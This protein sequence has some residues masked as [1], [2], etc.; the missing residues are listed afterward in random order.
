MP[1]DQLPSDPFARAVHQPDRAIDLARAALLIAR[2]QYPDLDID[3]YVDKLDRM[4]EA[5]RLNIAAESNHNENAEILNR[6]LFD[7]LGFAG[8]RQDYY[9]PHNS[10]LNYVLEH[11]TGIPITLSVVYIEVGRRLHLPIQGVGLPGHFIVRY[12]GATPA[13]IDPF[14][15]GERLTEVDC[16]QRLHAIFGAPV[17]FRAEWLEPVGKRQILTRMLH[18]LKGIYVRRED[19]GRAIPIVEKI[20]TLNPDAYTELRDLGSL[21]GMAGNYGDALIYLQQYLAHRPDAP[22]VDSVQ[23]QMR[24]LTTRMA[25]WN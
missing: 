1:H 8:N 11:R 4:A 13:F 7:E 17:A 25:R 12:D 19:F 5:V 6:Y 10:F 2:D 18:N 20:L 15:A 3:H 24:R 16:Q 21:H 23:S 22:D 9:N 14:N